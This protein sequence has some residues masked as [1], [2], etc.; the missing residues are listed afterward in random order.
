MEAWAER[1]GVELVPIEPGKPTQNA[2]IERFNRTFRGEVLD[3]YVFGEL[4][5]VRDESTRWLY[6]Y[7]HDRPHLALDRQPPVAYRARHESER[8]RLADPSGRGCA[9]PYRISQ[10]EEPLMT[11]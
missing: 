9:P 1:H 4:D 3:V 11:C 7:N 10:A 6:D 8:D 5:E 2:Y